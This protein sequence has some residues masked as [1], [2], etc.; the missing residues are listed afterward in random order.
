MQGHPSH[1]A[2]SYAAQAFRPLRCTCAA[3]G[4]SPRWLCR[5]CR[6]AVESSAAE[7][8]AT[9]PQTLKLTYDAPTVG[10]EVRATA[11]GLPAG[12]TVDLTWETV[13]GGWV[14]EDYYHFRG[15]K[16]SKATSSLGKFTVDAQGRLEA[17]FHIPEDYGGVHDVIALIDGKPVA[18]NGI[19]VTQSFEMN[20]TSGPGR[21]AR[22]ASGQGTRVA[23]DGK[24]VGGELGQQPARVRV[25]G[26]YEGIR[27]RTVSRGADQSA[28]TA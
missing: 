3:R 9:P 12:Q 23:D 10:A 7:S 25:G 15:K 24:H 21:D 19:E 8:S 2:G 26:R 17:R 16:Y 18:Q 4:C 6:V 28:R 1:V 22:R 5:H 11:T 27:G 14:V 20:P 13:T